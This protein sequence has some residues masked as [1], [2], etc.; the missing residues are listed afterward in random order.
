[1]NSTA[2]TMTT[3]PLTLI[4]G[5]LESAL[6]DRKKSGGR[7]GTATAVHHRNHVKRVLTAVIDGDGLLSVGYTF[8][9][10]RSGKS[11]SR[12]SIVRGGRDTL[13][14][15]RIRRDEWGERL[16]YWDWGNIR[17]LECELFNAYN[18]VCKAV[19]C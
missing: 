14:V 15:E 16:T 9:D 7:T 10:K 4:T 19:L 6:A 2:K 5:L 3:L 18:T 8:T 12:R 17:Q 11:V 1:M 13:R